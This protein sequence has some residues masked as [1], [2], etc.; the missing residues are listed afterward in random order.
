MQPE[1]S[2]DQ[3]HALFLVG[4]VVLFPPLYRGGWAFNSG[5]MTAWVHR[6][7]K[8]RLWKNQTVTTCGVGDVYTSEIPLWRNGLMFSLYEIWWN[9]I[10]IVLKILMNH[11]EQSRIRALPLACPGCSHATWAD[12]APSFCFG[13]GNRLGLALLQDFGG[14]VANWCGLAQGSCTN[15]SS[16]TKWTA[17]WLSICSKKMVHL[18][19]FILQ[20]IFGGERF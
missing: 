8:K 10:H 5:M 4:P 9:L 3:I 17:L 20:P 1:S 11:E 2:E 6:Q 12:T 18:N 13:W 16:D 14:F 7:F 19:S 15:W